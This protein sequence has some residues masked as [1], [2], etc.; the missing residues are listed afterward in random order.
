MPTSNLT[1]SSALIVMGGLFMV[2]LLCA[3]LLMRIIRQDKKG[4]KSQ[5]DDAAVHS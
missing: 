2:W 3:S 5:Q 1:L 4:S